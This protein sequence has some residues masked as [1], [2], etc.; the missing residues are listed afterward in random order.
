MSLI[1]CPKCGGREFS[2]IGGDLLIIKCLKCGYQFKVHTHQG[3][4]EVNGELIHWTEIEACKE[5]AQDLIQ[6]M[7][8]N[9][10][11]VEK[12]VDEVLKNFNKLDRKEVIRILKLVIKRLIG[13]AKLKD[14]KLHHFLTECY[15]K[16]SKLFKS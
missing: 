8:L 12:V 6:R 3:Y 13:E 1:S 11:D 4:L 14:E 7:L 9:Y 16:V 10:V 2:I 5:K 15:G